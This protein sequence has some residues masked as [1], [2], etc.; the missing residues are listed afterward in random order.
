MHMSTS[1]RSAGKAEPRAWPV[2][3]PAW[4]VALAI[5]IGL[6][7][8]ILLDATTG[9]FSTGYNGPLLRSAPAIAAFFSAGLVLD[10]F[11]V[12]AIWALVVPILGRLRTGPLQS[13]LLLGAVGLAVPVTMDVVRYRIHR[14]LGDM[15]SFE[16]LWGLAEENL[17]GALAEAVAELP[18][19]GLLVIGMAGAL[20]AAAFT[21]R[22]L[23]RRFG[24][25]DRPALPAPRHVWLATPAL[26]ML[27]A[28]ALLT[29]SA[30][31]PSVFWGLGLKP[32]GQVVSWLVQNLT[33][34]DRDGFGLLSLP[35]DPAPFDASIH[36]WALDIPGDGIDQ[37]G[38]GGVHP[39]DFEWQRPVTV[40][41]AVGEYRPPV[42]LVFL[43]TFRADLV[44]L[45]F[46][47]REVT[48]F[49][50]RLAEEGAASQFAYVHVP[51]TAH[52][53]EQFL[54]GRKVYEPGDTTLL[55]DLREQG[56][57][58]AHFSGQD[59]TH[60]RAV[61]RLGLDELDLFYDARQDSDLRTSRSTAP[62][63][64]QISWKLLL[65]RVEAF[66][67]SYD[68]G[69]PLFLYVNIVDTHFPY[70]HREL[71][72][73]LGVAGVARS[74]IRPENATKVWE[75]YLNAAANVDRAIEEL[76]GLWRQNVAG[77][78]GRILVTADHGQ[79]FYET[80]LLGHGT[81][82][83][84]LQT[85][86]PFILWGIGGDW[87]E[88]LGLADVRGLLSR[89]LFEAPGRA[90]FVP[91]P[92]REIFQHLGRID[93]PRAIALR[94]L[95]GSAIFDVRALRFD[96]LGPAD[97]PRPADPERD[98]TDRL[99]TIHTWE[100]IRLEHEAPELLAEALERAATQRTPPA[101]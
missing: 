96:R 46:R 15:V 55:D 38:M 93:Q 49:L 72:D 37:N 32:S 88:P 51:S 85:R 86:V 25:H 40:A 47:E 94:S 9:Y 21:L 89:H 2:A 48:P 91:D 64:L 74:D 35:P 13:L 70:H 97:Q 73:I 1:Q 52:S 68:S 36:P 23:E 19:A 77:E 26:G 42:L 65:S 82:L 20:A 28:A 27:A 24:L 83:D 62:V 45:R 5:A 79:S 14:V 101:L 100:R 30:H 81:A 71:D 29:A 84:E 6:G 98:E 75:A 17:G 44:G 22:Y 95:D 41:P 92:A 12:L 4:I 80:G 54:S 31:A 66:L 7:N 61:E 56:Y 34:V 16:V 39:I 58:I 11:L 18:P 60:G 50:N 67:T 76:V 43:E 78:E 57:F 3:W 87:P 8:A 63:S 59:D 10:L 53:R 69:R 90:R 99:R 33:D